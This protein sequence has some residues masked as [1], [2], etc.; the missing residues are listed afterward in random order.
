MTESAQTPVP[1]Q[2]AHGFLKQ[3]R[4]EFPVIRD[5]LPLAIGID[6]Q[7][8]ALQPEISRKLM[9]GALAIHTKS[10]RYLK[11]LQA[12]PQRFNLDGSPAG[13][14]SEEQRALA[15]QTLHAHFKKQADERKAVLAAEAAKQAEREREEKLL[16][17]ASKFSR[18]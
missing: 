3:L 10:L 15:A 13:E 4:Q 9:R 8:I 2:T 17:L 12:S 18:K 5:C 14:T 11:A 16:A 7:L 6:K 1:S